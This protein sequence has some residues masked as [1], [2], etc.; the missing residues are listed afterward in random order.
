MRR[1]VVLLVVALAATALTACGPRIG[2]CPVLPADNP[3][4]AEILSRP[5]HPESARWIGRL[6]ATRNL[7][8][9]FGADWDGGPF[10]IPYVVVGDGQ[11]R[12]PITFTAYGDESDPGPYP[13]P[14]DAPVEGGA[15]ADGDRH[16]IVVDTAGCRLYE[17]SRAFPDGGGWRADSGAVFD[18]RSNA[19]RPAGYTS[20]DAA[21][22]PIF[23]GLVRYDEVAAGRIP[24]AIRVTA[25]CTQRGYVSP[26]RHQAGSDDPSCPPMGARFRLRADFDVTRFTGQARVV[27]DA[28]RRHGM[29]VADNGSSWFLSGAP[30]ARWDDD[31]LGQLK[32]VPASAFEAI[33]TGPITR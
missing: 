5:V 7:H 21:G 10:G 13:V 28:L 6:G 31:D 19:L 30:D 12:V 15:G 8:P 9:D 29:V 27:L 14:L 32:R 1:P 16:V 11:P 33:D 17:L 22:L 18:L 26:A 23:P 24:H 20:A 2:N 3:W 25:A 4:N